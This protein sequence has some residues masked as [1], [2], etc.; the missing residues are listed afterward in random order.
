MFAS[1]ELREV[2]KRI[3]TGGSKMV[4]EILK[5]DNNNKIMNE[6]RTSNPI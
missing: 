2:N 5:D 6:C 1:K 3:F 4:D